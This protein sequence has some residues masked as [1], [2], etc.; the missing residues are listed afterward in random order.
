M[1][2]LGYGDNLDAMRK[3]IQDEPVDLV[4]VARPLRELDG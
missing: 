1:N 2:R 4:Y 3:H